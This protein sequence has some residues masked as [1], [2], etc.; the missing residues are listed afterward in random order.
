M[1]RIKSSFKAFL[2]SERHL[3]RFLIVYFTIVNVLTITKL[4]FF[5]TDHINF[6]AEIIREEIWWN[7]VYVIVTNFG[8][9]ISQWFM[10]NTIII[11]LYLA[12]RYFIKEP[13]VIKD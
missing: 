10:H 3:K 6:Y 2:S 9:L 13:A 5:F 12:I 1:E 7:A 11:I 4:I 8:S